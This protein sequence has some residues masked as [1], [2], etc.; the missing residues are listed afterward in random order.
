MAKNLVIVE[1]PAKARTLSGILGSDYEVQASIGHIR[2]LPVNGRLLPAEQKSKWWSDYAV[3]VDNG[4]EAIYEVPSGKKA[5]VKKLKDA[6]KGKDTLVLATDEDREGESISWHLLQVLNPGKSVRV[7]R[8]AF[9]E[10]TKEAIFKALRE[11]RD[12]DMKLVEAQEARRIL[13][14]L[15]G[16]TLS[17]VLWSKVTKNLSAGR[18]QTPAVKLVVEREELRRKFRTANYWG[19]KADLL[20]DSQPFT[21]E[22]KRIDSNRV[23]SGSDFDDATGELKGMAKDVL[24][25]G[26]SRSKE[27]A[28]GCKNSEPWTVTKVASREAAERSAP[29]FMTTTLQQDANRKFG[30]AADRTMRVAQSL[31]EGVSLGGDPVGLITYMRT[32]SLALAEE[33]ISAIRGLIRKEYPDCLP[34]KPEKYASKVRNAQEAHEAIRPTDVELKPKEL[35]K[36]LSDDQ[37]KLY[38]LIWKRTVACQMK[39]ARVLKTEASIDVT[40]GTETL[41]FDCS[42]KQ[43]LFDGFRRVYLE[44][45][46][47][48]DAERDAMER[49]LPLLKEGLIIDCKGAE[50]Q[51][52]NTKPPARFTDATLI[53][54]LEE[55][56]IGRPSTYASIISTIVDRGYVRK[57]AKQLVPTWMAYLTKEVLELNFQEFTNLDF[58]ARMDDALDD[59]AGG[60]ASSTQYLSEFFLGGADQPGLKKAVDERKRDIPYPAFELGVHPD[61]GEEL[62][63]R[64]GPSGN[65]F[66]QLGPKESKRYADIPEELAPA[67]LTIEKAL[68]LLEHRKSAPE[69]VGT[70]PGTGRNLLLR[71]RGGFYLEVER[72][73]EE[74]EAK[75]KPT[76]I[77]V[78]PGL[79]P[80]E[81]TQEQLDFLCSLP[82]TVGAHPEDGEPILFKVG[83]FGAYVEWGSERRTVEDWRSGETMGVEEAATLLA[84]P[85][86]ASARTK[87]SALLEL[88]ELEGAAGPVRVMSGRYGPYVTDGEVNATL[89][90]G[91][92]PNT[93]SS[94][95]AISLLQAKREAGPSKRPFKRGFKKTTK[96]VAK[97]KKKA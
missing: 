26:E 56:G 39:P 37:R 8:I 11:P 34:D 45:T 64:N 72:T 59:I 84:Q 52:H 42:G 10:I 85:K 76:W 63:V 32:D 16:Y 47:D 22:L 57:V 12:V 9:H 93:L 19:I 21:A 60:R 40:V 95:Q 24:L 29:P 13:D 73:E 14:R 7:Q 97:R 68:E 65:A 4:F 27:L 70:D 86:F 91:T 18:V 50:A 31:Y 51:P 89:P 55:Q 54:R 28:I 23:A 1:S 58:T 41:T 79:D 75:E 82:R 15:Y 83:K 69:S 43:I 17:P 35:A 38:D 61:T 94:D 77:S 20:S 96:A 92:D 90:K 49:R 62:L 2:D 74:I 25:L 36:F 3:D 53:K 44:G 87:P 71:N 6:M 67:D 33:A 88:G 80:R 66:L 30:F 48:P 81:L 46:D 5:Q 78:P